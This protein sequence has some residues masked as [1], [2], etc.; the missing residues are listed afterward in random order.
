MRGFS[1]ILWTLGA[2]A[3]VLVCYLISLQVATSRAELERVEHQIALASR[4]IRDLE[5]EIGTRGRLSQL[6]RWNVNFLQLSAPDADQFAA[7]AY[8]VAAMIRPEEPNRM[9]APIIFAEAPAA[10]SSES[11][12]LL[13]Q[14][15]METTRAVQKTGERKKVEKKS[16]VEGAGPQA[17]SPVER[18]ATPNPP[19]APTPKVEKPKAEK[20]SDPLA[21]LPVAGGS[22]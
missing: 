13:V 5:T 17:A 3:A 9:D 14:A 16:T 12:P 11:A 2:G 22:R 8:V 4:D 20:N 7:D 19:P 1:H 21:P 18:S 10:D 6:E 15:S